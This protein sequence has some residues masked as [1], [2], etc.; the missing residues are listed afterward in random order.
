MINNLSL[1]DY[2]LTHCNENMEQ[3]LAA[4]R[5]PIWQ[6]SCPEM[7]DI[8][9][10]RLGLLRC[11]SPVDSGRHFI[12]T[13]AEVHGELLPHSTYFKSLKS[14]RRT[15]ML[16]AIERQSYKILCH[17]LASSDIDYLKSFPE[18]D[19]YTVEAPDGHF[20]DHAC[21]TPKGSNGKVY[22]AGFIY[23][24]NLRNGLLRPLRCITNGTKRHHELPVLRNHIDDQNSQCNQ[25]EKNLYVYDKAVTDYPWWEKQTVHQNY[26]IS[27]LKENSVATWIKSI[28]FDSNNPTNTGIEDYSIYENQGVRFNVV[29]YRDPETQ[30]LHR[31]V[32]TLPE[33]INPG[34]IAI[35]YYKRWTIEKAYNNSKS[36]LKEK[37]AWS[38]SIKS[39]NNQMRLTTM[40]YN[41]MRVCEEISKKHDPELIHP[42]D[43]KYN[44]VLEERQRR[45]QKNGGFVNPLLFLERIVRISSYTIR[46][47]QNAIITGKSLVDLISALVARLVPG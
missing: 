16:E 44:K 43:K 17:H 9:F 32:S 6:R 10:I 28:A 11:I 27:V 25:P 42:S 4:E 37:K 41:L 8:D 15:R 26:M 33:S 21:H 7:S 34:T 36:N 29:H 3:A 5:Y 45:A 14:L 38:S 13:T 19:E 20:I 35:L 2:L 12:Q 23:A 18:L 47:V 31:F 24:M 30:K 39:L 22:A 46:A 1:N 40:T